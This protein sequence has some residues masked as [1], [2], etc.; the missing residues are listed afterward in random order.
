MTTPTAGRAATPE[1]GLTRLGRVISRVVSLLSFIGTVLLAV[2]VL[3]ITLDVASRYILNTPLP[4]TIEIVI[5]YHMIIIGFLSLSFT[6]EKNRNI[7]V[8]LVADLLPKRVQ[9]RLDVLASFVSVVV[10]GFLTYRNWVEAMKKFDILAFVTQGTTDIP[11]W[12]AYFVVPFGCA[13]VCLVALY[14]LICGL[15]GVKSGLDSE[16]FDVD[17]L[18]VPGEAA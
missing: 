16:L 8:E 3:H 12:P 15:T 17:E 10:F 13:M 4:G 6:E 11:I 5:N 14:K 18:T 2:M 7:S 1:R 9:L